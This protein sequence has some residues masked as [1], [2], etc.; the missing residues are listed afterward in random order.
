MDGASFRLL[1][2]LF[3][4]SLASSCATNKNVGYTKENLLHNKPIHLTTKMIE[5]IYG[6]PDTIYNYLP[7][8]IFSK[9][10]LR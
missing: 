8:K 2:F 1:F 5:D 9:D 7:F 10:S 3:I 6:N 4:S